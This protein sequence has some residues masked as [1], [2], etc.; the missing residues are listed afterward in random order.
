[1]LEGAAIMRGGASNVVGRRRSR[2]RCHGD[3]CGDQHC[4]RLK[5]LPVKAN[6]VIRMSSETGV[7]RLEAETGEPK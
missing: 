4:Q 1:M 2:S 5:A 6:F 3:H 7:Q